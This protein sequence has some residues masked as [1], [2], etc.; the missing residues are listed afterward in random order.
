MVINEL[1]A[2][3]QTNEIEPASADTSLPSVG[4]AE[5]RVRTLE[6]RWKS[7]GQ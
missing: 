5:K 7:M 6:D 2:E 1:Y 4:D 3:M